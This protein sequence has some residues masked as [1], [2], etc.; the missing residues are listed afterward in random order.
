MDRHQS[1]SQTRTFRWC[2]PICDTARFAVYETTDTY[3]AVNA[4]RTHIRSTDGHGHGPIHELPA[5]LDSET[6]AQY[7][8]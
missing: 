2:C 1:T 7:I 4:L 6:L 8:S 5:S 3:R